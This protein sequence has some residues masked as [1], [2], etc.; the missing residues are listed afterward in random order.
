MNVQWKCKIFIKINY[1]RLCTR[2]CE[3]TGIFIENYK[4][5]YPGPSK[6][7]YGPFELKSERKMSY[8]KKIG[9]KIRKNVSKKKQVDE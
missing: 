9:L 8:V 6:V 2:L 3:N 1:R 4:S 5:P 7:V